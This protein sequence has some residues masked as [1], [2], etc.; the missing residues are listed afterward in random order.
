MIEECAAVIAL[1]MASFSRVLSRPLAIVQVY[2][3][4]GI[5]LDMI[6]N[7]GFEYNGMHTRRRHPPL[8]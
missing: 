6:I 8:Y 3:G 7:F 5:T 4:I 1:A 2:V